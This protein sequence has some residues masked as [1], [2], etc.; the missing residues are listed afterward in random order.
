MITSKEQLNWSISSSLLN[1]LSFEW[2]HPLYFCLNTQFQL[3]ALFT[4][5]CKAISQQSHQPVEPL[6]SRAISQQ[7]LAEENRTPSVQFTRLVPSS[8]VLLLLFTDQGSNVTSHIVTLLPAAILPHHDGMCPPNCKPSYSLTPVN[9]A[10]TNPSGSYNHS[11]SSA[12]FADRRWRSVLQMDP[13]DWAP[14]PILKTTSQ[15]LQAARIRIRSCNY[16]R[17]LYYCRYQRIFKDITQI[18]ELNFVGRG[19]RQ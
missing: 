12:A 1:R 7:S 11:A 16:E 3:V 14:Q 9:V 15:I 17:D 2:N 5:A 6:A 4:Q 10:N 19:E 13:S 8:S 18:Q